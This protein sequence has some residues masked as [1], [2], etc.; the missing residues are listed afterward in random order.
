MAGENDIIDVMLKTLI[1][2][3]GWIFKKLFQFAWWIISSVFKGIWQLITK[4]KKD[5]QYSDDDNDLDNDNIPK[6]L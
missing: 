4:D 3:V 2:V 1:Q 5:S 6:Y